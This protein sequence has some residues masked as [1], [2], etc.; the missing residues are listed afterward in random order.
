MEKQIKQLA[1][2]KLMNYIAA[3]FYLLFMGL[4]ALE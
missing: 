1:K 2:S 3:V 4:A